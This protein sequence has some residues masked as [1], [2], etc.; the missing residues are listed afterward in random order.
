MSQRYVSQKELRKWVNSY[1]KT[2][3][4]KKGKTFN[5]YELGNETRNCF[6]GLG[7]LQQLL[8][9]ITNQNANLKTADQ[10]DGVRIY[11][12]RSKIHKHTLWIADKIPQI[13]FAIVP[14]CNYSNR[15]I[16]KGTGLDIYGCDDYF[17]TINKVKQTMC[18][19]VPN[20]RSEHT[21]LCPV[22]CKGS[23]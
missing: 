21:G 3:K 6:L 1:K 8:N 4:P 9:Y 20:E 15:G 22:N 19:F 7:E 13:G 11:L 14:T 23:L 17:E 10:I 18:I 2:I 12:T 16:D 5:T